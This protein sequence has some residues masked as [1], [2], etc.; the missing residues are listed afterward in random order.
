M[1]LKKEVTLSEFFH[2][3]SKKSTSLY[4]DFVFILTEKLNKNHAALIS[5]Q[6]SLTFKDQE[7]LYDWIQKKENDYPIQYFVNEVEFCGMS[8]YVEEGA[9]IP[10]MET[11]EIV[12]HALDIV[13]KNSIRVKK[14]IDVGAGT[15]CM[16]ISAAHNLKENLEKL[17]LLE[18]S[19]EALK[20]LQVN[21]ERFNI[22]GHE[23]Y[24]EPFENFVIEDKFDLILSNPPY[25]QLGDIDVQN[26]VYKY[27][28]HKALYGGSDPVSLIVLWANKSYH[29]LND[30]GLMVF[31]FSHDQKE[32][33]KQKLSHLKPKFY[34]DSFG[35]DRFFSVLKKEV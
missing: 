14:I 34:K 13:K 30:K 18:P 4:K 12:Y 11:E 16:G 17:V 25:I 21:I 32:Q 2:S 5:G 29:F 26:S 6:E 28:P 15:G 9:L 35:K 20:S 33:L 27:E 7:L 31:E 22:K 24:G 23:V 1:N 3:C 19:K 8:F 10:R